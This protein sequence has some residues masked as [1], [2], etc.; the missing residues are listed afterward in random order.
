MIDLKNIR[1]LS[2]FQRNAKA[3]IARIKKSGEPTVL[4]VN[5]KA[6]VVVQDVASFQSL[7]A[8]LELARSVAGIKRG[9]EQA[10][11]GE[12]RSMRDVLEALAK[13]KGLSLDE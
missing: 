1:S 13:R 10:N 4:T 2:E 6:E 5:G 12:G 3:Q 9:L 11:R 7:L 8:E